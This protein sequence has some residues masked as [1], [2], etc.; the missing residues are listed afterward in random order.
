[1]HRN[2]IARLFIVGCLCLLLL[3]GC[4]QGQHK[5]SEGPTYAVTRPTTQLTHDYARWEKSIA[6]FETQDQTNPPPKGGIEFTGASTIARWKTLAKDYPAN[7]VFNR[8][9]GGSMIC[10]VTHYADRMIFPYEPKMIFFRSGGNDLHA[11]MSVEEVFADYQTMVKTIHAR[12][13]NTTIVW[14]SLSPSPARWTERD[15]NK[16]LNGLVK[17][18]NHSRPYLK[19]IDCW[20]IPLT[21][22][23]QAREELFVADKLHF[24][25]E[26][27]KLLAE[28]VRPLMPK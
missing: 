28:R 24:N 12:L 5:S 15:A 8:G 17:A 2:Q 25:E 23:G 3:A 1:M 22:D 14:I 13:P 18:Y 27:Y 16:M 6:A 19:Y 7:K 21:K 11:G 9:F 10:D 20:D 26:G 4:S